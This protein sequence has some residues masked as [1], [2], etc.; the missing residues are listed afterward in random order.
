MNRLPTIEEIEKD[1]KE[2]VISLLKDRL[3]LKPEAFDEHHKAHYSYENVADCFWN[4]I[5]GT[6]EE[7]LWLKEKQPHADAI[8]LSQEE[9]AIVH[10]QF[11]EALT[12]T[13]KQSRKEAILEFVEKLKSKTT[14]TVNDAQFTFTITHEMLD[15]TLRECGIDD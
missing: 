15:E 9:W 5:K 10:Q 1:Y 8:V 14:T 6:I 2:W 7:L 11:A 12:N 3:D 13:H 4:D